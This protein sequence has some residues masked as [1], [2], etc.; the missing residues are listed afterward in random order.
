METFPVV[1]RE[2]R[3]VAGFAVDAAIIGA[4]HAVQMR[5]GGETLT[6]VLACRVAAVDAFADRMCGA[7]RIDEPVR[8]EPAAG[9]RYACACDVRSLEHSRGL[10]AEFRE[11]LDVASQTGG[12]A[13]SFRFPQ[14]TAEAPE[15]LLCVSARGAEMS[16]RSLHVYPNEGAVVQSETRLAAPS[17]DREGV[18]Q[19]VEV[20]SR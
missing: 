3:S 1:L 15:T 10:L 5:V 13:L 18:R 12:I 2:S 11:S 19:L 8:V 6:E 7:W 20:G 17:L 14:Q 4:S 9:F 16:I